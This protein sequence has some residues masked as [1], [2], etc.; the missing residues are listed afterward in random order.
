MDYKEIK[1]KYPDVL[2]LIRCDQFYL[3]YGQDAEDAV[4]ILNLAPAQVGGENVAGFP[5]GCLDVYLPKLIRAGKKM[6]ICE[7]YDKDKYSCQVV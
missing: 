7:E 4:H 1:R 3:K 5:F 2:V 6:A